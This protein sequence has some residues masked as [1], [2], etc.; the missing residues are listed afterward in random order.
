VESELFG[1]E[2]GAFTGAFRTTPGK[3]EMANKGTILLDE[4]GDMDFKLQAKLLQVLQDREFL[5]LGAK[6]TSRVDI[7]VMAATHCSLE[8][9]I[10]EGRF[11]E[12]LYY[13]L[14]I[15]EI[16]VPP[17]RERK[18]EIIK[19]ANFFLRKY[20]KDEPI[21]L[22]MRLGRAL[23]DHDWPGNVRELE[24]VIRRFLVFRNAELISAELRQKTRT[25]LA[26]GSAD[27]R[28]VSSEQLRPVFGGQPES[29]SV[30]AAPNGASEQSTANTG[31][32]DAHRL[33]S[34][35]AEVDQARKTA[36]IDVIIN[37][38]NST[39]WNRKQAAK[40][41]NIDYKALLY[42]MKKLSIGGAGGPVPASADRDSLPS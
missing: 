32:A 9:A 20:A 30:A 33:S 11:R 22:P 40:L 12:D 4:I 8:K 39:L 36:E 26:I 41:L 1:Y 7:R 18:D 31:A 34:N 15:V 37:A 5:R 42:K 28:T 16:H 24:N 3:F 25:T 29:R 13:R 38:L 21:E 14:N 6:D 27:Y 23:L 2:R 10:E 35:L 17:L 19:L